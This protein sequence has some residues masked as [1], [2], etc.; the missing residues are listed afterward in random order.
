MIEI[1]KNQ[2]NTFKYYYLIYNLNNLIK[3]KLN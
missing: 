2:I 1:I 3:T